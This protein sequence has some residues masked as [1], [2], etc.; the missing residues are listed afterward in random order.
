MILY[1]VQQI[2]VVRVAVF[3]HQ[4][5]IDV[6]IHPVQIIIVMLAWVAA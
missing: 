1:P 2:A 4:I 3:I 6:L 5:T